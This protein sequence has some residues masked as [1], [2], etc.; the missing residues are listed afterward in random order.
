MVHRII[1][2]NIK[3]PALFTH[4]N[5]KNWKENNR[6]KLHDGTWTTLT[7]LIQKAYSDHTIIQIDS[8]IPGNFSHRRVRF[9]PFFMSKRRFYRSILNI[10][11]I[12][13]TSFRNWSSSNRNKLLKITNH[14]IPTSRVRIYVDR[15]VTSLAT[16]ILDKNSHH[17]SWKK[18]ELVTFQR[19]EEEK[20]MA[21]WT[22]REMKT[23]KS[24][25]RDG[26]KAFE[27]VRN[28]GAI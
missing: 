9:I 16:L 19:C 20:W 25:T 26:G 8:V 3:W 28:W 24:K 17:I 21:F 7:T 2:K 6:N 11:S 1:I 12:L 10:E 4:S 13:K 27:T 5:R 22:G 15:S 23:V 14:Q 18:L